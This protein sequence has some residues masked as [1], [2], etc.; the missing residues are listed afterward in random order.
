MSD[1]RDR[2]RGL[3]YCRGRL[4]KDEQCDGDG[5]RGAQRNGE[6]GEKISAWTRHLRRA[7]FGATT[8]P[9]AD[10]MPLPFGVRYRGTIHLVAPSREDGRE[11][12][13]DPL[14]AATLRDMFFKRGPL[15]VVQRAVAF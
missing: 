7:G 9:A 8:N 4:K 3:E 11:V 13:A 14:T 6:P 2:L 10:R 1:P 5:G 12:I 15:G